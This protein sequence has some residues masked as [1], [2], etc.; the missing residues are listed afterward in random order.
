MTR[1]RILM[2]VTSNS[3]LGSIGR[4]TGI[5]AEELATP[6]FL[7]SDAGFDI[8]IASP[9]GGEAPLDPAS[10]KEAGKN[11]PAVERMLADATLMQN[12]G[13]THV[14]AS[15]DPSGYAAIFF[16]GG[17]GTMWDLASDQATARVVEYADANDIVIGAVCHGVSAL[18]A[19]K[20]KDGKPLV[21]GR[22]VNSFTNEEEAAAGLT[23]VMPFLLETRLQSL[24]AK[25]EKTANWQSFAIQDGALVTGQNPQSSQ[26]VADTVLAVLKQQRAAA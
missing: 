15:I 26:R 16:P 4:K 6:Y 7:F 25:F 11:S 3:A 18:V 19:A 20:R 2:I 17:H 1:A 12:L 14:T 9:A 22:R 23:D 8:D 21:E 5:W 13:S 24:G 10:V